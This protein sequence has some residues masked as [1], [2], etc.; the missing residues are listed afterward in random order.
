MPTLP[1]PPYSQS[2]YSTFTSQ[3][4]TL[5]TL[6]LF[7]LLGGVTGLTTLVV[8]VYKDT[9][10][11]GSTFVSLSGKV[12]QVSPAETA[13]PLLAAPVLDWTQLEGV[14]GITATYQ[15]PRRGRVTAGLLIDGVQWHN[16]T[17]TALLQH[18]IWVCHRAAR[19]E[20][21]GLPPPG[22]RQRGR[23][24]R[25]GCPLLVADRQRRPRSR[26]QA[27]RSVCRP[28]GCRL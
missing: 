25:C 18:P 8:H 19:V 26:E 12:M 20:R 13:V 21:R 11:E 27:G 4:L 16:H 1:H 14:R 9:K 24:V 17:A 5:A 28:R 22:R 15:D 6:T 7:L 10:A 3:A 2:R 23:A